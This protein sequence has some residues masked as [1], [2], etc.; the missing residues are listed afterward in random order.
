MLQS[1]FIHLSCATHK[2]M[3]KECLLLRILRKSIRKYDHLI[4][5]LCHFKQI[6]KALWGFGDE[7]QTWD[8]NIYSII[9]VITQTQ[10][11]IYFF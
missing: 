9:E 11:F 7:I 10:R 6:K 2:L 1:C 8:F 4:N 3:L 5:S